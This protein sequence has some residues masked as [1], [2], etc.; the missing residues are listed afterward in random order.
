M[1][2]TRTSLK[3]VLLALLALALLAVA[4]MLW[5]RF[6]FSRVE[7]DATTLESWRNVPVTTLAGAATAQAECETQYPLNKAWFGALH[8]H[9]E[10]SYDA[11][12]MG[13]TT[14]VDQAYSFARG[15]PL[16]LRLR[17]DPPDYEPPVLQISS[18][19]DF[20][21]VTDH[22]EALGERRLCY[23]ED[24]SGYNSLACRLYRGDLRLP[25]ADHLQ[26]LV[27]LV[28]FAIFGQDRSTRVCGADGSLCKATAET[29][30]RENQ[31]STETWHDSSVNCA[32][33]TFHA[34]E[35]TLAEQASNL[36]RNVIFKSSTVPQ[37]ALSAKDARTP[38]EL[39]QWLDQTCIKGNKECDALAIPHNSNWS[40]GRMWFP[41]TNRNIPEAQQRELAALRAKVEPLAE[42]M[43]VK[44]ESECR[45]G[46]ASVI[47]AAD[48]FCNFEKLRPAGEIIPDCAEEIGSGGMMLKGCT[49]RYSYLR[50]ALTAGLSEHS[51]LGVN[52]FKLGIVAASDTHI[53]APAVALEQGHQGSHGNDRDVY[54]RLISE[55]EV[56]GDIATGSPVRYNPGGIA[57]V[58]ARANSRQ[59]LFESMQRRETFGTSGPRISPRFFAGWDLDE[60]LCRQQN[61]LAAAYRDGVPMGGDI[62]PPPPG[63]LGSPVFVASAT[64]DPRD[65][66]NLLQRI[67]IIKGWIDRD[68]R[69]HQAVYHLAGNEQGDASVDPASCAVSGSGFTQL[70]GSWQDPDFDPSLA[71]VYYTRVLENPS[72][73]WS[74][75]DCLSLPE[76]LRPPSCSDPQLPWQIQERAWTS[77]I[78]YRPQQH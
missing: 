66:S 15:T 12:A 71:A 13:T 23:I 77:P 73:R 30:W 52:P 20:M 44:G 35:Y 32:F 49:S 72:C 4:A 50:Y 24:A 47:G 37:A 63:S 74:H 41:Y 45:N 26:S 14:T 9:T 28:S 19:L 5:L 16:P 54:S 3:Y 2:R 55:V 22:A 60:N 61:Y 38:E 76:D 7:H 8:V 39:W 18:P 57:G 68:G 36:H 34:Y 64:R 69:T 25:V 78:W 67:Q 31:R 21:A 51:K 43:Q 40:S 1:S 58:Y 10:A 65:G 62:S 70:C 46:I 48:E 17:E 33:T 59:A 53:G 27:R 6:E 56:P 11:T 29:A 42:I 75:Y